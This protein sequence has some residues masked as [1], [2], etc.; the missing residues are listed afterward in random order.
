MIV[1]ILFLLPAGYLDLF[2]EN[3]STL[4]LDTRGYFYLLFLGIITGTLLSYETSLIN[5][6]R[7]GWL[8]FLSLVLGTLIPH[9]VP[10]DLQGNLHL[11]FAYGGFV[12]MMVITYMNIYR[13]YDQNLLNIY[14]FIIFICAIL[15]IRYG[16]VNTLCEIIIMTFT[17]IINFILIEKKC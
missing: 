13:I 8:M 12:I 17:M 3:Y 9:H 14:Y 5:T 10:Y 2:H 16:M 11:L 6:K 7:T 4:S 1:Y 15:Y